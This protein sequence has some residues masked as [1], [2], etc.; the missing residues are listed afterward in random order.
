MRFTIFPLE[1][2]VNIIPNA[3]EHAHVPWI[4]ELHVINRF[5]ESVWQKIKLENWIL[6]GELK[7]EGKMQI[8]LHIL[9]FELYYVFKEYT[10]VKCDF[11]VD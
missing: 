4:I 1:N 10:Y 11:D 9:T 8:G 7:A 2:G 3:S 5:I 6:F